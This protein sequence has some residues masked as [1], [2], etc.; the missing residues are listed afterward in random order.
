MRVERAS[1]RSNPGGP[2][3]AMAIYPINL[4]SPG[5][6]P[7]AFWR[8]HARRFRPRCVTR[9]AALFLRCRGVACAA[10]AN[11]PGIPAAGGDRSDCGGVAA[12]SGGAAVP[13]YRDVQTAS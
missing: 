4:A 11:A 6:V 7:L 2:D 12:G 13:T 1:A 9:Q 5:A 8:R 3:V 10:V